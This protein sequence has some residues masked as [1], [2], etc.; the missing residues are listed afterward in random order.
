MV[1]RSQCADVVRRQL[2]R[3]GIRTLRHISANSLKNRVT[4]L[5]MNFS[6]NSLRF[7][8]PPISNEEGEWLNSDPEITGVL[9]GRHLYMVGQRREVYFIWDEVAI[10]EAF[11][12]PFAE[13]GIPFVLAMDDVLRSPGT[14]SL[15]SFLLASD[16]N[17]ETYDFEFSRKLFKVTDRSRDKV[18]WWYTPDALLYWKAHGDLRVSGIADFR[19]FT[20]Y[21]LLHVGV[22]ATRDSFECLLRAAH[23]AS[24]QVLP[25]ERLLTSE[26]SPAVEL[27][28]F[29]FA[30]EPTQKSMTRFGA[31]SAQLGSEL[32]T[33]DMQVIADA[34][35]AF[36]KLLEGK[37][38]DERL[39]SLA[40]G[41]KPFD[42]APLNRDF[43]LIDENIEFLTR[44]TYFRGAHENGLPWS[45]DCDIIHVEGGGAVIARLPSLDR[46]LR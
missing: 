17:A 32:S 30:A 9:Q 27:L 44:H 10:R 42:H 40:R 26:A 28:L 46:Q 14:L 4:I 3:S 21:R 33:E 1:Q 37:S 25:S 43:Y 18:V 23:Q 7:V 29:V 41:R 38:K 22:S 35:R 2:E 24:A 31:D 13:D 15:K 5:H 8:C 6:L 11:E 39:A 36:T 34:E 16:A 12:D 19:P 45:E 20:R